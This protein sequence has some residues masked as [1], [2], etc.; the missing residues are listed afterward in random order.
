[1]LDMR[2]YMKVVVFYILQNICNITTEHQPHIVNICEL[3]V[4]IHNLKIV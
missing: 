1:M 3:V 4:R 2:T